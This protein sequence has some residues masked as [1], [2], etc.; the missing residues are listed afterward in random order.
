MTCWLSYKGS[1][2]VGR[3]RVSRGQVPLC[4]HLCVAL[5]IQ[6][7]AI[8]HRSS[9]RVL[10]TCLYNIYRSPGA[11]LVLANLPLGDQRYRKVTISD[12]KLQPYHV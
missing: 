11:S 10:Q 4:R 12:G 3:S 5:A 8:S 2:Q 6:T 9:F 1:S 7:M